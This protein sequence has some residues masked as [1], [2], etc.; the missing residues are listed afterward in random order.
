M[1]GFRRAAPGDPVP[2]GQR[3]GPVLGVTVICSA[4]DAASAGQG[5]ALFE[6][7]PACTVTARTVSYLD[8]QSMGDSGSPAGR[9]Y[10]DSVTWTAGTEEAQ[11]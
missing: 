2:P 5:R 10:Y 11:R 1:C 3:D 4:A 7:M 8:L 6:A 9:R